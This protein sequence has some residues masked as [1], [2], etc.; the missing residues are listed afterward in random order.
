MPVIDEDV[1]MDDDMDISNPFK[2]RKDTAE[3]DEI[4]DKYS[5]LTNPQNNSVVNGKP[6]E[7]GDDDVLVQKPLAR[8]DSK[9][10]C[11]II[12]KPKKSLSE[13]LEL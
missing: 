3:E 8:E 10:D 5:T 12:V 4:I 1:K 7:N 6:Q 9:D 11:E 2:K 13:S